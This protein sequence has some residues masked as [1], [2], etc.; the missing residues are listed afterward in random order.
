MKK[1]SKIV[2]VNES[3]DLDDIGDKFKKQNA[4]EMLRSDSNNVQSLQSLAQV[5]DSEEPSK[6]G[7]S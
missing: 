3:N 7:T 4:G 6:R 2:E 1:M 5:T